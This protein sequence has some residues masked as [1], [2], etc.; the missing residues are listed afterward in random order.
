MQDNWW[1]RLVRTAKVWAQFV[2]TVALIALAIVSSVLFL[3]EPTSDK[4]ADALIVAT[5]STV[6]GSVLVSYQLA[7][8]REATKILTSVANSIAQQTLDLETANAARET[9][10]LP[11]FT[12]ALN[13]AVCNR[14]V[15]RTHL[16][17]LGSKTYKHLSAWQKLEELRRVHPEAIEEAEDRAS[18]KQLQ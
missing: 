15:R 11:F 1:S 13:Y 17:K 10:D 2:L 4:R 16:R 9:N 5:L 14:A 7:V 18:W 3:I 12:D 6:S 8:T